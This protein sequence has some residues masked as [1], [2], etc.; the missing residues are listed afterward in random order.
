MV[1]QR[2]LL[3]ELVAELIDEFRGDGGCLE[4]LVL[5]IDLSE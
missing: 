4:H 1:C 3:E 5:A 2:G